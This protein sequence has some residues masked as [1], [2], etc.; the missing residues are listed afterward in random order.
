MD[1]TRALA[2][3]RAAA[4]RRADGRAPAAVAGCA[5]ASVRASRASA[6]I[7]QG[8]C[9]MTSEGF[10]SIVGAGPGDPDLLRRRAGK[11]LR[12]ADLVLYDGLVPEAI[13]TLARRAKHRL[14]SRRPG[15]CRLAPAAA[16]ELMVDAA[17]AGGRVVRLR[18]GDPF[19]LARG[20][21]GILGLAAE[22]V[23]FGIV[24]GL[25]TVTAAATVRGRRRT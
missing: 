24:P 17:R 22:G 10:V 11:R 21:D 12:Q 14:V 5:R 20:A 13:V 3:P 16:V 1:A 8:S 15:T 18:A 4:S 19:V 25:A 7:D 6:S 2:P 9:T 23:A